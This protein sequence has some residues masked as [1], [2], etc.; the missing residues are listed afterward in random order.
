MRVQ[1]HIIG[2]RQLGFEIE[3]SL[4]VNFGTAGS[5]NV[6]Q[7]T[8][9][10]SVCHSDSVNHPQSKQIFT[11]MDAAKRNHLRIEDFV[12]IF[13]DTGDADKLRK[14]SDLEL[15]QKFIEDHST[16]SDSGVEHL[17]FEAFLASQS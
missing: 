6:H 16:K 17:E 7:F 5:I 12:R 8:A 1:I 11:L 15:V 4:L 2:V 14:P 9:C 3:P 10:I 13:A